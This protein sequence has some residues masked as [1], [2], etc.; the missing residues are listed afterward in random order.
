M[1]SAS[2]MGGRGRQGRVGLGREDNYASKEREGGRLI[3][4]PRKLRKGK[5]LS[6]FKSIHFSTYF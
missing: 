2:Y 4:K 3:C 1:L 6:T 5:K